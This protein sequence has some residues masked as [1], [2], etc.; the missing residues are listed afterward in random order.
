MTFHT[1]MEYGIW[2]ALIVESILALS[3]LFSGFGHRLRERGGAARRKNLA[4]RYRRSIQVATKTGGLDAVRDALA[5]I[6]DSARCRRD[7]ISRIVHHIL[8][9]GTDLA[10][11]EAMVAI[12]IGRLEKGA[13]RLCAFLA[14]TA[15][16]LGLAG[17]LVGMQACLSAHSTVSESPKQ[18]ISAG[19]GT[20]MNTTLFGIVV[21]FMCVLT[22][23]LFWEHSLKRT[24]VDMVESALAMRGPLL[25]FSADSRPAMPYLSNPDVPATALGQNVPQL[26][27][28]RPD[29][30]TGKVRDWSP[31]SEAESSRSTESQILSPE[32]LMQKER[33]LAHV[34]STPDQDNLKTTQNSPCGRRQGPKGQPTASDHIA[35]DR[36]GSKE[37]RDHDA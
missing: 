23:R 13:V 32:P 37:N 34:P 5:A 28:M 8:S 16:L 7:E 19:L 4:T 24:T 31:L 29:A 20:A 25:D 17:T 26:D 36:N 35:T 14:K 11:I 12:H 15:P 22:G 21:A 33:D 3:L 6:S 1:I 27:S 18:A 30:E 10:S 9:S 2:T